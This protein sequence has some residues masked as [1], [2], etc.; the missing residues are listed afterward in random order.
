M[1]EKTKAVVSAAILLVVNVAA[2]FGASLDLGMV[3]NVAFGLITIVTTLYGVWK[4][5]NFTP[6]AVEA[7][8]Y[9]DDLKRGE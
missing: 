2:L 1:D 4:N 5:H 3:Q 7:Q 8:A 9:L 6:E